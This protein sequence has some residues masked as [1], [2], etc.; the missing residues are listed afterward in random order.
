MSPAFWR[1]RR[2]FLTGHTGFK[3]GWL[4]LWLEALGAQVHG[5]A[6]P[7]P[8]DPNL[9]EAAQVQRRLAGHTLGDLA[10]RDLVA[11]ALRAAEPEVVFHLAAQPLVRLAYA[12]PVETF[13]TNIM[14]T[15]HLL[16]A[17]RAC[18]SVRAVVNVTTD[19]CYENREWDWGY[20]ESDALGGADPYAA[21]KACSE[22]VSAAYRSSFLAA[23]GVALATARAGNVIGGGD[24]A[25]DRLLP[26]AFR[27][28]DAGKPLTIRAPGA[29]RPWQ[30]ALEP[31]SGYLRLAERLCQEGAP[32]AGAWNFGPADEGARS[33]AALLSRL[34][35]LEP[36]FR[37]VHDAAPQPH[38]TTLLRLDSSRARLRLGWQPRWD[39]DTA[40]RMS[41]DWHRAW[42]QGRDMGEFTVAQIRAHTPLAE[43]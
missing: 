21:S 17:V 9:F 41:L 14:G 23:S 37:W 8:T 3:G 20:R 40:L 22:L 16:E 24:W 28:L 1:G 10:D 32:F 25:A 15:V 34:V 19:K 13:A 31:L 6:L 42:R 36:A 30:H 39:L 12:Q 4:A 5:F 7:P 11:R 2:V 33:V 29:V 18:P 35:E 26:D 43:P 38:E 27:A